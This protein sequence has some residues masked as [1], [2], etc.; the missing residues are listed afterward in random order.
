MNSETKEIL[1]SMG[2]QDKQF[3]GLYRSL[4]SVFQFPDCSMWIM[5]YL[6]MENA[7]LTQHEL[8]DRMMYSKQTI[9]SAVSWLVKKGWVRLETNP[10]SRSS[11]F[12]ILTDEGKQAAEGTVC[13]I[14]SAEAK[15][16][17]A[18]GKDKMEQFIALQEELSKQFLSAF[19]AEGLLDMEQDMEPVE[20]WHKSAGGEE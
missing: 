7:P 12:V 13:R 18:V 11:K 1:R 4:A 16:V 8:I 6:A 17:D 14:L 15:A 20:I 9:H 19:Q 5:Y 3:E 2:R 10:A